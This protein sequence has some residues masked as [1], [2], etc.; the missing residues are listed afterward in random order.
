MA[1]GQFHLYGTIN[2]E[3]LYTIERNPTGYIRGWNI[4]GNGTTSNDLSQNKES[5]K[6]SGFNSLYL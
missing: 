1:K 4:H 6:V 5:N 2:K 3:E